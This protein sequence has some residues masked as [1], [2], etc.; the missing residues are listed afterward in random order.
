MRTTM[1]ERDVL[2]AKLKELPRSSDR[3]DGF[4]LPLQLRDE[5]LRHLA[6]ARMAEVETL[7]G[8]EWG[9]RAAAGDALARVEDNEPFIACWISKDDK[10]QEVVKWT[11]ANTTFL[12]IGSMA[13]C[14][15]E[16][17]NSCIRQAFDERSR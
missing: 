7:R 5:V 17:A 2:L 6:P 8:K 16:F 1:L 13:L 11:K 15:L 14:L 3:L 10:G 12:N 4:V 9:A